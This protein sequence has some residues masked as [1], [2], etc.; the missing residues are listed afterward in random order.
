[1]DF[2]AHDGLAAL[3]SGEEGEASP[4][5]GLAALV[6]E[7]AHGMIVTRLDGRVTH[8]NQAARQELAR[9]RVLTLRQHR[10]HAIDGASHEALHQALARA[11]DGKRSLVDLQAAD[12]PALPVA[13][14]P[15]KAARLSHGPRVALLFARSAVCDSLM[16]CFFARRHGLTR[17]EEQVLGILCEGYS[18]P[19]AAVQLK[20]AVSTVR[21]HVRSLCAKTRTHSVRELVTRLAV[22]PP[23]APA[24]WR[25]PVH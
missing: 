5:P 8:V 11:L 7:L 3:G 1:M 13:L 16:L 6:D 14:V 25:E 19:Q 2:I 20:V 23:L 15:L 21:S 10:L 9:E 4:G 24:F 17:T 18:A 22:L 12:G